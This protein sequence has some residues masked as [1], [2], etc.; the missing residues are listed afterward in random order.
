MN[1]FRRFELSFLEGGVARR[2][3]FATSI[4]TNRRKQKSVITLR[5]GKFS[6]LA[7]AKVNNRLREARVN[8]GEVPSTSIPR[9]T[10]SMLPLS[11][12]LSV[13][14]IVGIH[15]MASFFK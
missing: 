15:E 14:L 1:F 4:A 7:G 8:F 5:E 2:E 11:T 10:R 9:E 12:S 13:Q 6:A 3:T